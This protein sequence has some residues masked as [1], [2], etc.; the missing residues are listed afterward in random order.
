MNENAKANQQQPEVVSSAAPPAP[1]DPPP[2]DPIPTKPA[3]QQQLRDTEQKIEE[4][5]EERMTGFERSMVRLTR[6][7]LAVTILTAFVFAGQLYEMISGG[8]QTDKLITAA[9]T[10]AGAATQ[11]SGA[12]D[13]FKDSAYWMEQHMD[14]AA[15]AMQDSVDTA[16]RNTKTTIRNA[17]DALHLDQ[18]AWVGMT[19]MELQPAQPIAADTDVLFTAFI[20]NSGKTPALIVKSK[21]HWK[22][23]GPGGPLVAA[24]MS[25]PQGYVVLFPGT[26]LSV[27]TDPIRLTH[28]ELEILKT[29]TIVFKVW[30]EIT[31]QDISNRPHWTHFCAFLAKDLKNLSA[32][33]EYNETDDKAN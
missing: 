24:P 5:I 17:Q 1:V 12:A 7:G 29:G 20:T 23:I 19:H 3:T 28:D 15:N 11:I 18:R 13:D 25:T 21:I 33:D 8:T 26:P 14:D 31:Y 9:Q 27:S 22:G 4:Q 10:Q 30:G 2:V 16:D 6:Y 32:C